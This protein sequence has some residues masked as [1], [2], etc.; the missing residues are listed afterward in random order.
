MT[1]GYIA[2]PSFIQRQLRVLDLLHPERSS[3]ALPLLLEL[4]G[5]PDTAALRAA[6]AAVVARH[7]ALR[8]A[9]PLVDGSPVMA[10]RDHLEL[11]IPE[12]VVYVETRD[13]W[14]AALRSAA[15]EFT[16]RP[17]DLTAGP[18]LRAGI[19][20]SE[21][22][23]Y[24]LVVV[25]HHIIA[26]GASLDIFARD[27]VTAYDAVLS[28]SE[29][30][31][32]ELALQFPD[33]S[34]WEH[35]RYSD[36]AAAETAAATAAWRDKLRG[37][38]QLLSLPYDHASANDAPPA[39]GVATLQLDSIVG[40]RLSAFARERGVTP[41]LT[42]LAV[43]AVVLRRWTAL[44]DIVVTVP[45]SK[46]TQ[47]ELAPL[48]GLLVDTLP[49]RLRF[50]P[51]LNFLQLMDTLRATFLEAL[52]HRS[53]P[54]DRILQAI[55]LERQGE[56]TSL[57]QL[58]FG[59]I[60]DTAPLPAARDGVVFSLAD[61]TVNQAAKTDISLVYRLSS[62]GLELWCRYDANRFEASTINRLLG[63]FGTVARRVVDDPS[64]PVD[65]IALADEVEVRELLASFNDTQ[66]PYS[67][68]TSVPA[69]FY[70]VAQ[71][72][73]QATAI[74]TPDG[75][76][77][78]REL[79]DQARGLASVLE[80]EGVSRGDPVVLVL[81]PSAT[82]IRSILAVLTL[83]ASYVTVDPAYPQA[84]KEQIVVLVGA[85]IVLG[86]PAVAGSASGEL[87]G[88]RY[89]DPA[90][91]AARAQ[92]AAPHRGTSVA[93][94]EAAYV[95]FT[96]GSTGVPKGVVIPHRAIL[97]LVCNT[98]YCTFGPE[99]RA[100]VYSNPAFD[101]S[102]LEIWA[103]LLNGGAAVVADRESVMDP[104]SLQKLLTERHINLLWI[105]AGLFQQIAAVNSAVFAGERTVITGGDVVN[106]TAARGVVEACAG[107]GLRL[108]NGYGPTENT[109]FSTTFDITEAEDIS[110]GVPIGRPIANS[111]AYVLDP[112]GR[113]L[114]VGIVGEI[115]VGGAGVALGY[116]SD[117]DMTAARFLPDPFAERQGALM[118]RTGDL[119]R[120]RA[121][122]VLEFVG[123][124][125][126]QVKVR[127]FRIEL[128]EIAASLAQHPQVAEVC[129]VA[130]RVED[131]NRRLVAYFV[132]GGRTV[133][134]PATLRDFLAQR[135]APHMLPHAYVALEELPL[136]I[137]G[138]IDRAALP[139]V[140]THHFDRSAGLVAPRNDDEKLFAR[141]WSD[142]LELPEV[143]IHENF[144]Q[145]GGDSILA[146]RLV[147]R[148]A[149]LG[150]RLSPRDVFENPTVADLAAL[151]NK[152][153]QQDGG[154][155]QFHP[156]ELLPPVSRP[157]E[158]A[159][160]AS[161]DIEEPVSL[162]D[163]G[164]AVQE[165]AARHEA[166]RVR[167]DHD[168]L[169]H[170][171]AI[172][173]FVAA[174]PLRTATMPEL[175]DASLDEWISHHRERLSRGLSLAKGSV[176][177]VT[178]VAS[179]EAARCLLV[180]ALH[181]SIA[182]DRA[183]ILIASEIAELLRRPD[184]AQHWERPPSFATWLAWLDSYARK[185]GGLPQV[186]KPANAK[187]PCLEAPRTDDHIAAELALP[188]D[189]ATILLAEL[190]PRL[191]LSPLDLLL[192]CLAD[193]FPHVEE[194][195]VVEVSN[196]H[197]TIPDGAP[198]ADLL[199]GNLS[200]SYPVV[201]PASKGS[202]KR[203]L[204]ATKAARQASE[205]LSVAGHLSVDGTDAEAAHV[206]LAWCLPRTARRGAR[207]HGHPA[208]SRKVPGALLASVE[209]GSLLLRW[210]GTEPRQGA[211]AMLRR[212]ADEL[213][214]MSR[215]LDQPT[216][217]L[218]TPADMPLAG[219]DLDS[220]EALT[221]DGAEVDIYRLSPMQEAMLV[222]SLTARGSEVNFEQ[223]CTRFSGSI[224]MKAFVEAWRLV[225][226]RHPVLRTTF[227]WRG[228]PHPVQVVRQAVD[229]PLT[230]VSWPEFDPARLEDCLA[231]DRQQGFDLEE[232]PLVRLQ[233]IQVGRNE[234]YLIAS[235]HHLIID[236]WCLAQ[237]DYELRAAYEAIR[238]EQPL[239]LPP[240][241]PYR[242]Y[243]AWLG[244]IEREQ[245]RRYFQELLRD[246][247]QQRA[248]RQTPTTLGFAN[249]QTTLDAETTRTIT[250]FAR[251]RGTTV[252][253][254]LHLAWGLW[255]A[256][257]LGSDD[258]IFGTTV[259]G[260]PHEVAGVERIVGLFINNLP[261]RLR[262]STDTGVNSL[263][264]EVGR[265]L[266]Y[267]QENAQITPL[268]VLEVAG[269]DDDRKGLFDT[270]VVVEN[271]P[272][273]SS[274][275]ADAKG[276]V[277][278]SVYGRLKT[279]YDLTFVAVPGERLRLSLILPDSDG[280]AENTGNSFLAEVAAILARLP[281]AAAGAVSALPLP[282]AMDSPSSSHVENKGS[283]AR[284]VVRPRSGMEARVAS[285]VAELADC[286]VDLDTDFGSLGFDSLAIS[287]LASRLGRQLGRSV[288]I[289]MLLEHSSIASLAAALG[290]NQPW[291]PVV[292][293]REGK[294]D[295]FVCVHPIAGDV[296]A[297]IDLA[298][299]MPSQI[300][301]W[302]IQAPGLEEG[303]KPLSS[304]EEL[305]DL[306]LSALA[307]RGLERPP[308]IGGYSFG[309]LVAYEMARRLAAAGAPPR[310][311]IIDT[312]APLERRSILSSDEDR[313]SAEW[314]ARMIAV[315]ARH[316]ACP[317]PLTLET[318]QDLPAEQ[319]FELAIE[320]LRHSGLVSEEADAAW[321]KRAHATGL[322]QYRAYLAYT[323]EAADHRSLDLAL[324]RAASPRREDLEEAQARQLQSP[325]LGWEHFVDTPIE[326]AA[327]EGDHISIMFGDAAAT[328]AEAI[329]RY[330]P[331]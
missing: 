279:A 45:V 180:V 39:S 43:Y 183:A 239:L 330:L 15:D 209:K 233:A 191:K 33:Y 290:R 316:H 291:D 78:Y 255:L 21:R 172:A 259:S 16:A 326:V 292:Q 189:L 14:R 161:I 225:F 77:S 196:S 95:M 179:E 139:P 289:S 97:R 131:G 80:E 82:L 44:E 300:P 275:W 231:R 150:A 34:D 192:A 294:G 163:L 35:E 266:G 165:V 160:I 60:T 223:S 37:L 262:L 243:I 68:S 144:F 51:E 106:P 177:A 8:A 13:D 182:D 211:K 224:E 238:A 91:L 72:H 73:P 87:E 319:R 83:G 100:L 274:A 253:A 212:I 46:R 226:E 268:E 56:A 126:D 167:L 5:K 29:P 76:L 237:L 242:N 168:G 288:P 105:T 23:G 18:L 331:R 287:R 246:A 217:P 204:R 170:H 305:A 115:F 120:W 48:I 12:T 136:T 1:S 232:G 307:A 110:S 158:T 153:R 149:E 296:S 79:S 280:T 67:N 61:E 228:L 104:P 176:L 63:W 227:R 162:V 210:M 17:F 187:T 222:H 277:V 252:A 58:L 201:L 301:F 309:G 143:G 236:G 59:E 10:I 186:P 30:A 90:K 86:S 66:R 269:I 22:Y 270:L 188:S 108:L 103:P 47:P 42:F 185:S 137:N 65:E 38:P 155:R 249:A 3:Y 295:P 263:L 304:V 260:R 181:R 234:L 113:P 200:L 254:L 135:L 327:I 119:G 127:G 2:Q 208:F 123:R 174:F 146:I 140:A 310:T 62:K 314:L 53:V 220:L 278:E 138:K 318:L 107:S 169:G 11:S 276:L 286:D 27:L 85:R 50:T 55:G 284:I 164:L 240:A 157:Q 320:R 302:A 4:S 325:F 257:K 199:I 147:T 214:S 299:A 265:Q 92:R 322:A 202:P 40:E 213:E 109:T 36:P 32:P 25:F 317:V 122:G 206:G 207:S 52:R 102:T 283:A 261:L 9:F 117:A 175:D 148:A 145:I 311:I 184:R 244:E 273:G 94:D 154:A 205:P 258:V 89:L 303:Q 128:N 26:D 69:L 297:F 282:E 112:G 20:Y 272:S 133:P 142:L 324:I 306:A 19:L 130:P 96:S 251:R 166:L 198:T 98:N 248:L 125:D 315:R 221:R 93:P 7:D 74:E 99:T 132:A 151:I 75:S 216:A 24:G 230:V 171:L 293:L 54:F 203:R 264:D 178:L 159:A 219:L 141:L 116:V 88:V 31:W 195:L 84:R 6:V 101:A 267:L 156:P 197:R 134:T 64:L 49:L 271:L 308:C 152:S 193:A 235:F 256:A 229:L 70:T 313:A 190:A 194:P 298:R 129:V 329:T 81:H 28:G 114:P 173:D 328:L 118:Y 281:Q 218:Y 111:T 121:D 215:L 285:T 124:S 71:N 323:P 241:L 245:G 250:S 312:P 41:F 57:L 247:P 321:L